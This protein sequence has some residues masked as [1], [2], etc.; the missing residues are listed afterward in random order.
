[1][2]SNRQ[3]VIETQ[4]LTVSYN[5]KR[6]IENLDLAVEEGEVF[7]LL[8]PN[9]AGKTTI[10]RVL[11]DLIR[12][13][14]GIARIFGL[15][16]RDYAVAVRRRIGYAPSRF[17]AYP[18]MR[19]DDLFNFI[20]SIRKATGDRN[21][22]VELCDRLN[23]DP[24]WKM[25]QYTTMD[26]KRIGFIASL[27]HNPEL[28][29]LDE[30]LSDSGTDST[31]SVDYPDLA[32]AVARLVGQGR[33]WRGIIVDGAGIGSCMAANKVPGVRASLCYDQASAVNSREHNDANVLTL[34]AGLIGPHLARQ[35]VKTWLDTP[36]GGGWHA[37]R[38]N[39]IMEIEQHFLKSGTKE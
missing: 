16:C 30:P 36:F 9:G 12:P 37:R 35:I 31:A 10:I 21:L 14:R 24:R 25:K 23:I 34:G 4:Q 5:H 1:M 27:L 7:G 22:R 3:Y 13:T 32:F 15:D 11:L 2:G 29:I 20:D 18:N 33:A 28:L 39:K 17:A 8:G 6:A 38:V 19:A 26:R